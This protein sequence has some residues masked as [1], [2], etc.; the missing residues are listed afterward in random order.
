[1]SIAYDTSASGTT[2]SGS[3][4][5]HSH[6]MATGT[7]G[8]IF[9]FVHCQTLASISSV[10]YNGDATTLLTSWTITGFSADRYAAIYY[11]VAP[12]TG[13]HDVVTTFSGTTNGS[14][15]SV[16]YLGAL[17]SGIPDAL[18]STG[19]GNVNNSTVSSSSPSS[20]ADLSWKIF[21]FLSAT[22]THSASTGSTGRTINLSN[23]GI[24][25]VF[26]SNSAITPAGTYSMEVSVSGS[27][28]YAYIMF[29]FAPFIYSH[30]Q[31]DTITISEPTLVAY[32]TRNVS[33]TDTISITDSYSEPEWINGGKSSTTWTNQSK[34]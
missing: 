28:N 13:T 33:N 16:S 3:S 21:W 15:Q 34:S 26:D 24:S 10:T 29:T 5:T 32:N 1:M 12:D 7:A 20:V 2:A 4:I 25:S 8:I 23:S 30:T 31:L 6:T 9:F 27:T 18:G 19:S 22:G 17:Q 14:C 11:R